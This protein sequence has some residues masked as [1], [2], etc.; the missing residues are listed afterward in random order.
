VSKKPAPL[1]LDAIRAENTT[2]VGPRCS[3]HVFLKTLPKEER[4]VVM[5]ALT[6]TTI[7]AKAL[8]KVLRAR[9][10]TRSEQ[11]IAR[12]RWQGCHSCGTQAVS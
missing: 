8:S 1:T 11:V 2:Y 4:A 5:Q 7:Q 9:G 3:L 12:H 10:Y 6:D